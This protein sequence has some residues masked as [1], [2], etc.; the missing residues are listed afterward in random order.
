MISR[1][2]IADLSTEQ[3]REILAE[4]IAKQQGVPV[5]SPL[6]YAQERIWFLEQLQPG[7][8]LFNVTS[9]VRLTGEL[10]VPV[11]ERTF[12]EIVR[13][14]E[15]LRGTFSTVDG[16]PVQIIAPPR[17]MPLPVID[18]SELGESD[19]EAEMLRL[20]SE[21]AR[22]AID[23]TKGPLLR[24]ALLRLERNN[25]VIVVVIHHIVFDGWSQALLIREFVSLYEAFCKGEPSSLLELPIQYADFA[26]WQRR[27]LQE[28]AQQTQL[29]YWRTQ[30]EGIPVLELPLDYPR[31]AIRTS[32][33][34]RHPLA[35]PEKIIGR[36]KA[37]SHQQ[38]TTLFMTLLAAFSA[39]LYRNTGQR[40][41]PVGFLI[42]NRR[43]PETQDLIGF[44]ANTLVLR[45]DLSDDP[46]YRQLL[47]QV[48]DSAL[49]AYTHQDLPFE[50]LVAE[51]QTE[52]NLSHTPLFQAMFVLQNAPRESLTVR[53]LTLTPVEVETRASQFDL[54]LNLTEAGD[55]LN[56][57]FDY[58]SDLFKP[59]T[60]G[61]MVDH[62]QTLLEGVVADP[63]QKISRLPMLTAAEQHQ[64][65][66]WNDT[67]TRSSDDSCIHELFESR[68]RQAPDA[69]AVILGDV[70][71][72]YGELNA[73]ANQLARHLAGLGVGPEEVVGVYL[74][75]SIELIVALLGILKAGGA[76]LPLDPTYPA[77]RLELMIEEVQVK[78]IVSGDYLAKNL[79]NAGARVVCLNRPDVEIAGQS[80]EDLPRSAT[81]DNLA[82]VIYTSGSTGRPKGVLLQHR[83]LCNLAEAQIRAFELAPD[84]RELQFASFSFDASV[85]EIFTA[86]LSGASLCLVDNQTLM[87]G[88]KLMALL[89]D[90]CVTTVTLPPSMLAAL[91]YEE[92][93]SL[94]TL[95]AAGEAC[96]SALVERWSRGRRFLNAYGPTEATVCAT[97]AEN[98]YGNI[99]AHIGR[100]IANVQVHL[101]DIEGNPVPIGVR[102]ELHIGGAGLARG[103]SNWPELT[104]QE[105][106]PNPFGKE[107]GARLYK[108][109]DLASYLPDGNI[110]F[111]GRI[112]NQ[113]KIRGFRVDLAEVQ[114]VLARRP[115]VRDAYV[116]VHEGKAG[117]SRLVAYVTTDHDQMTTDKL[118]S[119]LRS[120][121]PDYM[122]PSWFI[123]LENL[124]LSPN[125][126][127]DRRALPDPQSA[128][129]DLEA[130]YVTPGTEMERAIAAVWQDVL[131]VD[132]V[133]VHANFFDLGGHSL[134]MMRVLSRL[135][136]IVDR[137]ISAIEMF[138]YPTIE[139][140]AKHLS[141]QETEPLALHL[142]SDRGKTRRQS[143]KRQ[144]EMRQRDRRSMK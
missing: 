121:V 144:R 101:L 3:Q 122:V 114:A 65:A 106:I 41:I 126:K 117:E 85:S 13:R 83:G 71:L 25:H 31:P 27:W 108:S 48:Y 137:E 96:S 92:L 53:G 76:Y 23:L 120:E 136:R 12:N 59:S 7:R 38:G 67:D 84:S 118:R 74:D 36:L 138:K 42:A 37:L 140:L 11:V 105:F 1:K 64:L 6:S 52:R 93:S 141:R 35:L 82:Y 95:I 46:T 4:L 104:A 60:I 28:G 29:A 100:P 78:L 18:L 9:A 128:R 21:R 81:A 139:S 49:D 125:G 87:S 115:H 51:L 107:P 132:K 15:V 50:K 88:S 133:G 43:R 44:F 98:A 130:A 89:R 124:P 77:H 34:T 56:G 16:E 33:G 102:G 143:M 39:L 113:V 131:Q 69:V 111:L 2:S 62:F 112:D 22:Q 142:E 19:R 66:V 129:S 68:V 47:R 97:I 8:P 119:N 58:N 75:R 61:R 5:P 79:P 99:R 55:R 91:P 45:I 30:L 10:N 103:Y 73:R 116:V 135:G 20:V 14:H 90:L 72:T 127:V 94:K 57:S 134:L 86:L 54:T 110:E 24:T 70:W 63:D 32:R 123:K 17:A 109:G 26:V 40:E 80:K